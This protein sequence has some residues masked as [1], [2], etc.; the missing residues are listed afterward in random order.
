M[1]KSLKNR[2][3]EDKEKYTVPKTVQDYI[4][5]TTIYKDG[6]FKVGNKYSKSFK[7]TDINYL[8]ANE[9]DKQQMFL[10]YS[11]LLNSFDSEA[12]TKIT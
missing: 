4:P 9:E 5:I 10:Q 7:F 1:M 6:I 12:I 8:T 2:I 11:E 3:K